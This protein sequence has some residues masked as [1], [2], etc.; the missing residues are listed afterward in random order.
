MTPCHRASKSTRS[1]Q[2]H[3]FLTA[4]TTSAAHSARPSSGTPRSASM[5]SRPA[6]CSTPMRAT[7]SSSR[8]APHTGSTS[9]AIPPAVRRFRRRATNRSCAQFLSEARSGSRPAVQRG[10]TVGTKRRQFDSTGVKIRRIGVGQTR[11]E[12][13]MS[14]WWVGFLNRVSRRGQRRNRRH[15]RGPTSSEHRTSPRQYGRG[16]SHPVK[17]FR[18]GTSNRPCWRER[19]HRG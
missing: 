3:S 4:P 5:G 1:G 15:Q 13:R 6:W 17:N 19:D 8:D 14:V 2:Q 12:G 11:L 9:I 18:I 10:N 7:C 16:G